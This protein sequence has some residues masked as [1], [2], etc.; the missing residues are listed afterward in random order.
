MEQSQEETTTTGPPP[1]GAPSTTT[2]IMN[3]VPKAV[4]E[5]LHLIQL[6]RAQQVRQDR[7]ARG[8][9]DFPLG[10]GGSNSDP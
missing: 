8:E 6:R 5:L 2:G 1:G 7:A 3:N 4:Y 10:R 9:A